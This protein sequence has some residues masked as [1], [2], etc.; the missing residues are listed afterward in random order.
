MGISMPRAWTGICLLPVLM[1][2]AAVVAAAG[3]WILRAGDTEVTDTQLAVEVDRI[4]AAQGLVGAP[5]PEQVHALALSLFK[6]AALAAES[7]K[8]G[9]ERDHDVQAALESARQNILASALVRA[10]RQRIELPDLEQAARDH[11]DTHTRDFWVPAAIYPSHIL[12]AMSCDCV[13]CDCLEERARQAAAVKAALDR[14]RAGESFA[15]LAVELSEDVQTADKGGS[16]GGWFTRDELDPAFARAAF[17]M[18]TGEVSEPVLTRFGY[19]LIKVDRRVEEST[20]SFD[21]VKP[22]LVKSLQDQYLQTQIAE[23]V[24]SFEAP[25]AAS[26]N[27]DAIVRLQ[28]RLDAEAPDQPPNKVPV[29]ETTAKD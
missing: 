23:F 9:M 24:A 28:E 10:Q 15:D 12:F 8:Q 21:D 2:S 16:L 22:L 17:A 14:I 26:W 6:T 29:P 19:H 18:A 11:Y 20:Q 1:G 7:V 4:R 3:D 27:S 25:E 13:E 5:P